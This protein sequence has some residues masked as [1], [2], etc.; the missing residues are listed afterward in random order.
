MIGPR[1]RPETIRAA[2]F[3]FCT[4]SLNDPHWTA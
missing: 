2:M 1:H 3:G 4:P